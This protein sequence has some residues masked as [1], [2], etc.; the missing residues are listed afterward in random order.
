VA[1]SFVVAMD[2]N[3][4]IGRDG[5]LPWRLPRDLKHFRK[6][7][8]GKPIVMGRKTYESIGRPLPGRR[9]IVLSRGEVAGPPEVLVARSAD[10]ALEIAHREGAAEA[11]IVGGGQVYEAFLDQCRTIHLTVVEGRFQGD[12]F[13]PFDPLASPDWRRA[14]QERWPA[15][16]DNPFD[17]EY[18]VL[19][20]DPAGSAMG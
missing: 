8:W 3:R 10:E 11:M 7:T 5:A 13:F 14:R 20:R 19:E 2:R 6:L 17:A 9:N 12:T 1:V 18:V 16:A 15:D 4:L